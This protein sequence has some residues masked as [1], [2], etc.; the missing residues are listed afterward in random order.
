MVHYI[1]RAKDKTSRS[2]AQGRLSPQQSLPSPNSHVSPPFRHPLPHPRRQFLDILYAI[3][4]IFMRV[5]REFWKL[6]VTI[7]TPKNKKRIQMGLVKHIVHKIH[8][9]VC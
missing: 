7:M 2:Q 6:A 8:T 3:L 4:C 9:F 5:F 1:V